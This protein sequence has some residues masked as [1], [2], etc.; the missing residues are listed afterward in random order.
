M[1]NGWIC[2]EHS[3][4]CHLK[5]GFPVEGCPK[6]SND[7]KKPAAIKTKSYTNIEVEMHTKT[8]ELA[9]NSLALLPEKFLLK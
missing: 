3:Q 9:T 7:D 8:E 6:D 2:G 5:S 4:K 1:M